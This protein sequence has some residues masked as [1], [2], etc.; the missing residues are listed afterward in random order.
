MQDGGY[1]HFK[2]LFNGYN[3]VAIARIGTKFAQRLKL[4]SRKHFPVFD[5]V[6]DGGDRHFEI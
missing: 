2:F 5:K 3:S 6:Q 1:G 4:T